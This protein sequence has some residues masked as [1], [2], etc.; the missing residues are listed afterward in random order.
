[1]ADEPSWDEIFNPAGTEPRSPN[2]P[3]PP[4]PTAPSDD[5]PASRREARERAAAAVRVPLFCTSA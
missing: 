4:E 5:A 1:M 2:T 3:A